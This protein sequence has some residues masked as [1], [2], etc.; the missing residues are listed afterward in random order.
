M[1]AEVYA[2]GPFVL[3]VL[4]RRLT[5]D[6]GPVSLA[7]KAFELLVALVEQRGRL[8]TKSALLD[9]VWPD[10]HVEEGI[11][12]VHVASLR[13]ALGDHAGAPLYIETVPRAGYRFVGGVT[14]GTTATEPMSLRWPV[15]VLPANP[16]V[17]ELIGRGRAHLLTSARAEIPKAIDAFQSAIALDPT[18]AAA[19]AGLALAHCAAGELRIAPHVAAYEAARA[20][21]LRALAMDA[22]SADAHVALGAVLF[23]NDWNWT[24]AERALMR[25]L[26]LAP[27]HLDGRLFYGRLLDARGHGERALAI[28]QKA[29]EVAPDSARVHLQI[30]HTCW[31]LRRYDEVIGWA[32]RA[33]A[34]D[35][36]HLLAREYLCG[37][38]LKKGNEHR[39]FAESLAHAEH[40][41]APAAVLTAL[42]AAHAAGG[43]RGV[44]QYSLDQ[45][46][47]R[48]PALGLAIIN[49][50]L[51]NLDAAFEYLHRAIDGRDPCL[52]DLAVGPQWD[53]LRGDVRF[54]RCLA[55]TGLSDVAVGFA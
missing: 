30:A 39:Y 6:A 44:L 34:L 10:A 7:P 21:A 37:A 50:D 11:L 53:A 1:A 54:D 23:L 12:A 3:D 33:L 25:A 51:G 2:F 5:G 49:G 48:G 32:N 46:S 38:W 26:S 42:E 36:T 47:P 45:M 4:D 8:V 55:R 52:V 20:A 28:K 19:H 17:S 41:G 9:R 13:K 16:A 24:G 43:R 35:P 22:D 27:D 29:L 40:A 31:H 14:R 15:G 18:Y